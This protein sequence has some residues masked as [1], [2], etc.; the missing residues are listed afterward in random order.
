VGTGTGVLAIAL[1][2]RTRTLLLATDIDPIAVRTTRDN[3]VANGVG[4]MVVA[5]EATGLHHV[6]ITGNAPYDLIV[7][8]ILAGPL[9]KL[10]PGMGRIAQ[11]GASV[12]L[13][14]ILNHQARGVINSYRAQGFV[15]EQRLIRKDWSTLILRKA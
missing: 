14:G 8:N 12:I 13:S 10:A 5:L 6:G 9:M 11:P 7:A 3:A 2:K 15:L 4:T 1:A